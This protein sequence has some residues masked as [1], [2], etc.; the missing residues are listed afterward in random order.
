[1][2]RNLP[3]FVVYL[4][5]LLQSIGPVSA[6]SMFGGYGV[7][8]DGV[9]FGLVSENNFYLKVDAALKPKFLERGLVPF[10]YPR[11]GKM[12]EMSYF[13]APEDVFESLEIMRD[14]ANA[15][16]AVAL[17]EARRKSKIR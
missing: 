8:L 14:W 3:E 13:Q 6:K 12:I 1:M 10:E 11:N 9:M 17:R 15:S 7:Y 4:L 2:N 16:Y 5:D